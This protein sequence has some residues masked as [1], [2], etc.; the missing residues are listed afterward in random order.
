MSIHLFEHNQKAYEAV[1]EMLEKDGMAA[2][3]HP[4]GTGKSMIAFKLV[5]EH[6]LN[7]FLWLSPSEYIY[8]TQV[9]NL[10]MKFPNILFMSY[11]RLM[12]NEDC[13]ETLHPDY[14]ILDEFHRCGAREWGKSIKKLL[15]TYPDARR[16]GL[17]ATNIRYL[18]NQR[19]MAKEIFNGKIASEMTLG[20]A[21]VREILPEPKYVIAMYS[22]RKE[23]DQLKKRIQT[24]SNQGLV[25]ENQK[26]LEQL[27]RAL[28]QADGLEQVFQKHMEK[29][30]GKYIVFC[31]DKEH[32]DEMKEQVPVWFGQVDSRPHIY[33]AFYNDTATDKEF[34]AFKKDDSGHLK[35]LFCID[36]L[37]EGVH[38]DDVD[39]V[40]LLRPTVSPIIYL[41]QIGRALSAGSK[42]TPVIFD[43]VNNFDSLCCIDCLKNEME[44]AFVLFPTS[45]GE[46]AHFS[47]R[48]RIIDETK[49]SRIL[50]RKLQA[51]LSSAWDTYYTAARQ[52]YQEKGNL[53]IP[54]SYVTST[55]L[56]LGSWIQTQR[57]VYSGAVTGG[58][59][60]EKVRK[61]NE[62]GMIWDARDQSWN[63]ALAE[64]QT[65]F[66]EHGNLDIKARY[67]TPDGFKL[68][69][70]VCNLRTKVR[71]KGLDQALTPEQQQQLAELGMIWDRNSEKWEDYFEA[72]E[73]YYK[74][75][76]NLDVMTKYVTENGLPLGR[77]LSEIS[78]QV[79]GENQDQISL[80]EE[81][82]KR[83]RS[84]GF[85][86][87]KKTDRQ[88]NEKYMLARNYYETYGNLNIP[89][90]YSING[91]RLGRWIANVRSK[92]KHPASSGMVLGEERIRQLDSIG[93][94]WK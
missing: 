89:L 17:S 59:T 51:N 32:M 52:W 48:F 7:H 22:Y 54:K 1:T 55:G 18:D 72:A 47:D 28:E 92:R 64:L 84:I 39:G 58:L 73:N 45:Y 33:T 82:L 31:S 42:K 29:K 87:E 4:T 81:Q 16:L 76:G 91:V 79:C 5:E 86:Q 70:W 74:T 40:V 85:R 63:N 71:T 68:G 2:V 20:E 93:M 10:N 12:K 57:R 30:D 61:L 6:P 37:N 69:R 19:N 53:R 9:E 66:N 38:V 26:L 27:R 56:T 77:W 44:E 15:D 21:I 35:L 94:N 14:I 46:R 23:L 83:L 50:F 67:E 41:Q 80:S 3:I 24:L 13:I 65:Y 62:I 8:Q 90:S 88:W 60:E 34:A 25:A 11:S 78:H 49:D 43:L 75:H 36:M